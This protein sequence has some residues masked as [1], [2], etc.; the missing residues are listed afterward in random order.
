MINLWLQIIYQASFYIDSN[1]YFTLEF[2]YIWR[3]LFKNTTPSFLSALFLI[4]SQNIF[5]RKSRFFS[6]ITLFLN[7]SN[8]I[9]HKRV[10]I[11]GRVACIFYKVHSFYSDSVASNLEQRSI[12][13]SQVTYCSYYE[14]S[15]AR[16]MNWDTV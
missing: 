16:L 1:V 7:T 5:K 6:Y 3:T 8:L 11:L 4:I 9:F 2:W 10:S 15:N 13:K 12:T 14:F